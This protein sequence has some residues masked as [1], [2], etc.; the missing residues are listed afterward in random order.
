MQIKN[1]IL[2]TKSL[3]SLSN[4]NQQGTKI[5]SRDQNLSKIKDQSKITYKFSYYRTHQ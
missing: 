5:K 3:I 1:H 4:L 2:K